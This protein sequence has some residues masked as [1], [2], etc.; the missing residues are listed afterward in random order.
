MYQCFSCRESQL[1]HASAILDRDTAQGQHMLSNT[2]TA[3]KAPLPTKVIIATQTAAERDKNS[4]LR[5]T[6][7]DKQTTQPNEDRSAY[8]AKHQAPKLSAMLQKFAH[9]ASLAGTATSKSKRKPQE[10]QEVDR[11]K[12]A[13]SVFLLRR[14]LGADS[15]A[16][17]RSALGRFV[18]DEQPANEAQLGNAKDASSADGSVVYYPAQDEM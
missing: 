10:A 18:D 9:P 5:L 3:Q 16:A 12:R 13:A 6:A 1:D 8:E 4:D 11:S 7:V 2:E 14:F 17:M 15:V